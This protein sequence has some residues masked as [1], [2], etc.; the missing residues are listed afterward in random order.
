VQPARFLQ[1][2]ATKNQEQDRGNLA[3]VQAE[4]DKTMDDNRS[5]INAIEGG[6]SLRCRRR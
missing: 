3:N 5:S 2:P 1:A 4:T 6:A